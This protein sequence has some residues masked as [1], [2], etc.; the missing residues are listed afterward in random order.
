MPAVDPST[1]NMLI[2]WDQNMPLLGGGMGQ[3]LLQLS[4]ELLLSKGLFELD[5]LL[6]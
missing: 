1:I 5:I 3:L 4:K 6:C 2:L